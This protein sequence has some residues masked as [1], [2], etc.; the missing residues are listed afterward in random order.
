MKL[1][2]LILSSFSLSLLSDSVLDKF[3]IIIKNDLTFN[4]RSLDSNNEISESVGSLIHDGEVILINVDS[5]FKE[6]YQIS[7]KTIDI[8]DFDFNQSRSISIFRPEVSSP[9]DFIFPKSLDSFFLFD[10]NSSTDI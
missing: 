7:D 4:H 9:D 5:P 10:C 2:I 6:R 1:L 3:N 8:Y